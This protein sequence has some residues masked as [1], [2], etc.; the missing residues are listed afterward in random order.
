[1]YTITFNSNIYHDIA[2]YINS[3]C[4]PLQAELHT[5]L[6]LLLEMHK[7]ISR[8]RDGTKMPYAS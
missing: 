8:E 4:H 1:M 6:G 5:Y 7:D 2:E 3:V